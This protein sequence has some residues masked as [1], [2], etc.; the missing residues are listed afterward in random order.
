MQMAITNKSLIG[1]MDFRV[2]LFQEQQ[3]TCS[4]HFSWDME[5]DTY[6]IESMYACIWG[7]GEICSTYKKSINQV[8]TKSTFY[9]HVLIIIK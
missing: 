7:K 3:P 9:G 1:Y 6:L 4:I 8:E 5:L 2:C